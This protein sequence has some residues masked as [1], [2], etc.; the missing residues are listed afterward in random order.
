MHLLTQRVN[1]EYVT[2]VLF[3]VELLV[4]HV[5]HHANKDVWNH[6]QIDNSIVKAF[7]GFCVGT[8]FQNGTTHGAL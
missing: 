4:N 7:G 5:A 6:H 1:T 8:G 3:L 2:K